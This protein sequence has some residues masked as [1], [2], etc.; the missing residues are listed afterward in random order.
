MVWRNTF[1]HFVLGP[2]YICS[3]FKCMMK[4][5]EGK[6]K[7]CLVQTVKNGYKW[8]GTKNWLIHLASDLVTSCCLHVLHLVTRAR[9]R[10]IFY[11]DVLIVHIFSFTWIRNCRRSEYDT[12]FIINSHWSWFKKY[13]CFTNKR[14][15]LIL[16]WCHSYKD[17]NVYSGLKK[18][19]S[20][21]SKYV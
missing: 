14:L 8:L 1:W 20:A 19:F 12:L 17:E 11:F 10:N 4:Q 5:L 6:F 2:Y 13:N 21:F 3:I 15:L 7:Y 18:W 16:K 9:S